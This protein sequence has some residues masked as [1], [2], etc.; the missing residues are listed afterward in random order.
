MPS[1][2][3]RPAASS[4]DD[5]PIDDAADDASDDVGADA[6]GDDEP[7]VAPERRRP[8][9]YNPAYRRLNEA[10]ER[11]PAAAAGSWWTR[12]QS[13][14]EFASAAA[15]LQGSRGAARIKTPINFVD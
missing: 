12:G 7:I 3:Q 15:K 11:A 4:G 2:A 9:S 5:T 8:K 1:A 6:L 10:Q 14:E 13:R